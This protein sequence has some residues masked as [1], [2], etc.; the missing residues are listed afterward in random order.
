MK[1]KLM[2]KISFLKKLDVVAATAKASR[3]K[4]KM[5]KITF[6]N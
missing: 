4:A 1:T 6:L 5:T 3:D 2:T